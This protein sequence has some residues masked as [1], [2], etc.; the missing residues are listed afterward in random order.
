MSS[1]Q[2]GLAGAGDDQD[3]RKRKDYDNR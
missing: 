3:F 2:Q 1:S